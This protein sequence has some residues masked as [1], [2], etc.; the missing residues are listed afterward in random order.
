MELNYIIL[1][2]VAF[3]CL[4]YSIII[5][6]FCANSF[7]LLQSIPGIC[8]GLGIIATFINMYL[9]FRDFNAESDTNDLIK[10]ISPA[11]LGSLIGISA[12][13]I[14]TPFIKNKIDKLDREIES[15]NPNPYTLLSEIVT[16]TKDT[17][18]AL[19]VLTEQNKEINDVFLRELKKES[20]ELNFKLVEDFKVALTNSLQKSSEEA[21]KESLDKMN[22]INDSFKEKLAELQTSNS[23]LIAKQIEDSNKKI[24]DYSQGSAEQ[25]SIMLKA[26]TENIDTLNSNLLKLSDDTAS[27]FDKAMDNVTNS[28][29]T[30][31]TKTHDS[32]NNIES[33]INSM[34]ENLSQGADA[35]INARLEELDANFCAASKLIEGRT[36]ELNDYFDKLNNGQLRSET[37][38]SEVTNRFADSV[39]QFENSNTQKTELLDEMRVQLS[40]ITQLRERG[41]TIITECDRIMG[42]IDQLRDRVSEIN[43]VVSQLDGIKEQLNNLSNTHK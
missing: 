9:V 14:Q 12:G 15:Q 21:I 6:K 26:F 10:D 41:S 24:E 11:F 17:N 30:I 18:L 28:V 38:L 37:L 31:S 29:E 25:I 19:K 43:N 34:G 7:R 1:I 2:I 32:V 5:W 42:G 39:L 27:K 40:E 20:S 4:L 3:F 16:N 22:E 36:K 33:K 35:I 8:M 23:V 13:L